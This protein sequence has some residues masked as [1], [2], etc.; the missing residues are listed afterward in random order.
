MID[1]LII[2]VMGVLSAWSGGSLWP[3]QYLPKRL[4]WLPEAVFALGFGYAVFPLIGYY[5]VIAI[6]WSY[7]WM[8]SATGPGLH[9]G[10]S[11]YRP[12]RTSTLKP[13]VDWINRA[14]KFDPST[15]NYCRLYMSVK[16]FLI[17]LP[18]GGLPLLVG[19]PLGY[20]IGYRLGSNTIRE[21]A[22]GCFAGLSIYLFMLLFA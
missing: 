1:L 22:A 8:Q 6:I 15:A 5:A 7:A 13:F 4:T 20:E 17:G 14:F 21:F 19:W 18:V 10:D 2:P 12:D 16:G 9:W 11:G 3:A